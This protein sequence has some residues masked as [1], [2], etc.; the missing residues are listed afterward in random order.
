MKKAALV[1]E[2]GGMRGVYTC[3]VLDAFLK[4]R[5]IFPVAY[6]V[7]A[8]VCHACSY[9]SRQPGRAFRTVYDYSGDRRYMSLKSLVTTG[10]Y[11]G[12]DMVYR[13]IPEELLPFDFDTF[14]AKGEKLYAA[15]TDC[16]TGKAGY[17]PVGD[18]RRDMDVIRASSSL[19]LLSRPVV[20]GGVPYLDGGITDSIPIKKALEDGSR[21]NIAVLTRSG[22]YRKSPGRS[23]GMVRLRYPQYPAL[24]KAV[25]DRH[26]HYNRALELVEEEEKA[27]RAVV[28]R[29]GKRVELDRLERD[30]NKLLALYRDGRADGAAAIP[31]IIEMLGERA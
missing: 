18:L 4:E 22:D 24:A 19:P 28:I 29:P 15:V 21:L 14:A 5:I 10:E 1:L 26:S 27:G 30:K 9:F 3:G 11:F 8:G 23:A 16:R 17:L 7:S 25:A 6:G 2:G 13:R 31:R 20:I 12:V